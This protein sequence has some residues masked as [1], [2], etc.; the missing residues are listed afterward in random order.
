MVQEECPGVLIDFCS[1]FSE[2]HDLYETRL[3]V[4]PFYFF[5]I[6]FSGE[7]GSC[8]VSIKLLLTRFVCM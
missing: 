5:L 1:I 7:Q 6:I 8:L 4:N 3:T 2:S